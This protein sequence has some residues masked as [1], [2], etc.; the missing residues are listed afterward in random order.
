[1]QR[2]NNPSQVILNSKFASFLI[3][4]GCLMI[5]SNNSQAQNIK[6]VILKKEG[7]LHVDSFNLALKLELVDNYLQKGDYSKGNLLIENI[8]NEF[9]LT[10]SYK[11]KATL[12]LA[13]TKKYL[14]ENDIALINFLK[15]RKLFYAQNGFEGLAETNI[16]LME[17]YRRIGKYKEAEHYY[18][19]SLDIINKR[20]IDNPK[21]IN[22]LYNRF[23]AVLNETSRGEISIKYSVK[24]IEIAEKIQDSN[25]LAISYN[26]LAFSYKNKF[27][28]NKSVEYYKRAEQILK[29]NGYDIGAAEAKVNLIQMQCHNDL[30]DSKTRIKEIDKVLKL[31]DSLGFTHLKVALLREKA[32]AFFIEKDWENAYYNQGELYWV[33]ADE[34]NA[35]NEVAINKINSEFNN[36][37]LK[38][39]NSVME[40]ENEIKQAELANKRKEF[41]YLLVLMVVV[42]SVLILVSWLFRKLRKSHKILILREHQKTLLVQEIHHRVKNN[43]QFVRSI[44]DLQLRQDKK[45]NRVDNDNLKDVARRIDAM[46]IVHELLYLEEDQTG[47]SVKD[48]LKKLMSSSSELF[49]TD[50][51]INVTFDI[52]DAEI[53]IE[54][55][56][57]IGIICAELFNNTIKHT[58]GKAGGIAFSVSFREMD[59]EFTLNVK[60]ENCDKNESCDK[61]YQGLGMKIIDIF[62]RQLRGEYSIGEYTLDKKNGYEYKLNFP[63]KEV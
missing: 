3:L 28:V 46:T 42:I 41:F 14:D 47:I 37:L 5:Y 25:A 43:L 10:K 32:T 23:A 11:A 21:I 59:D 15:A 36:Q 63:K 16:E 4:L 53:E 29:T 48:Y 26:E 13:R 20:Q 57:A 44:I 38:K 31:V 24:A 1:M 2:I 6:D 56:M 27:E 62:S 18:Y 58:K 22:H 30:I 52:C 12:L 7:M 39:R 19:V 35:K 60:N 40:R 9:N 50:D 17:F 45:D 54:R 8:F 34:M 51:L 55:A 33:Q 49:E 61:E